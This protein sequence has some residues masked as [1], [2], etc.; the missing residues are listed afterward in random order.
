[1]QVA[2]IMLRAIDNKGVVYFPYS[3]EGDWRDDEKRMIDSAI[4]EHVPERVL[5]TFNNWRFTKGSDS[6]FMAKRFT[7][8]LPIAETSARALAERI[9]NYYEFD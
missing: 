1:M 3:F 7:W 5:A 8:D 9:T 4:V 6:F 2:N